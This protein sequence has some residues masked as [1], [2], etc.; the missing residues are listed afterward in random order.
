MQYQLCSTVRAAAF[1]LALGIAG[2]AAGITRKQGRR[3][4]EPSGGSELPIKA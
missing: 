1:F 4:A 2:A 3:H